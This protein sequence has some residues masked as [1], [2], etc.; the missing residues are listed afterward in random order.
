MFNRNR[1]RYSDQKAKKLN[2]DVISY[3]EVPLDDYEK[4]TTR[5]STVDAKK[6]VKIVIVLLI[7]GLIVFAFANRG[8]LT[9]ENIS[10]WFKY[11]VLGQGEGKGYPVN[12]VGTNVDANN[13]ITVGNTLSYASDTSFVTLSSNASEIQN[14][15]L[16]YAAPVVSNDGN[17]LLVYSLGGNDYNVGTTNEI[18]YTGKTED[19]IFT[20]DIS[21]SGVYGIV[22]QTSGYLSKLY[23][24]NKENKQIY[25]YSFADYYIT[26]LSI[27]P[28]GTQCV[29]CG[30]SAK[31]G[32]FSGMIYVLD[33]KQEEPLGT[34]EI[35][36]N[37]I[38]RSE[39]LSSNEVCLI[40][41][42]ASYLL[43]VSD[44]S[45]NENSNNQ[46]LLTAYEVNE[47]TGNYSISLSR[48]GDGHSCTVK[49]FNSTG[50]IVSEIETDYKISALT[51]QKGNIYILEN[52]TV[53]C[54]DYSG[55]EKSSGDA[56]SGAK[57]IKV[58]SDGTVF[59]IGVNEIRKAE[60]N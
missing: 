30:I 34:Y 33:F 10:N 15:Q 32:S 25:A 24:F 38:Y 43:N 55:N 18:K 23:I 37:V 16:S 6:I 35:N 20:G 42:T 36:E 27:N 17:N 53:H 2:R 28:S 13:M 41:D 40:G 22:T 46:M 31:E 56:G 21:G 47:N 49:T 1:R 48:T 29:A 44:G 11:D 57:Q 12:I 3:E 52:N 39:Y 19:N 5:V 50:D 45:L 14:F 8:N 9:P 60:L 4:E 58:S 59:V 26:S 7:L 51:L 54:Y